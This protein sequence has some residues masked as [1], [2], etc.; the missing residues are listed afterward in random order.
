MQGE[1]ILKSCIFWV[2]TP[3]IPFKVRLYFGRNY[4]LHLPAFTQ[5]SRLAY[6]ST[7]M[8]QATCSSEMSVDFRRTI[9]RFIFITIA[10]KPL[11]SC[12]KNTCML[13]F[14]VS[15][16]EFMN[17]VWFVQ[18]FEK[19]VTNGSQLEA[20][21]SSHSGYDNPQGYILWTLVCRFKATSHLGK[22]KWKKSLRLFKCVPPES[23]GFT[24]VS[25]VELWISG[26]WI[27]GR[28]WLT[29]SVHMD[30]GQE[31]YSSISIHL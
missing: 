8:M 23:F 16:Q 11:K 7:L 6:P 10:V 28:H 1:N 5:A 2:K 4:R 31:C 25:K 12:K 18:H 30:L 17:W 27:L 3:C 29:F 24:W 20:T 14:T 13:Q 15:T 22:R 9:R 26:F 21:N 19:S